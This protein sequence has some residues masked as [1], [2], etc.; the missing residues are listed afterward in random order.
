MATAGETIRA[1]LIADAPTAA[2]VGT[3]VYPNE[4]PQNVTLPAL[5]YNV[6]SDVPENSF[7]GDTSTRLKAVRLQ[8][9]CYA[10]AIGSVGSYAGAH[11]VADCVENVIGNLSEP[12]LSGNYESSRDLYDNVTQYHRVSMDFTIWR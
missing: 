2:L 7:T 1:R 4:L 12:G 5:V 8:V 11:E 6:V 3:R 10:R 9:D